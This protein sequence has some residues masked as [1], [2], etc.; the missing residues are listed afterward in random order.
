MSTADHGRALLALLTRNDGSALAAIEERE[1][2]ARARV[3][4][5]RVERERIAAEEYAARI[6]ESLGERE[7]EPLERDESGRV[8]L[9][10]C[11]AEVGR[12]FEAIGVALDLAIGGELGPLLA[13][14]ARAE[15]G[16]TRARVALD[17]QPYRGP[18]DELHRFRNRLVLLRFDVRAIARDAC[19]RAGIDP[20]ASLGLP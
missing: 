5:E 13:A 2:E 10:V 11:G 14:I 18:G 9:A 7:R 17:A 19:A 12:A 8:S 20:P 3:E 16:I 15:E 1:R 4:S 6:A